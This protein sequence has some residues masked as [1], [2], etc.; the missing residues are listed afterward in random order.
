MKLAVLQSAGFLPIPEFTAEDVRGVMVAMGQP[1]LTIDE[2]ILETL[3]RTQVD[4]LILPYVRGNFSER[5]MAGLL[6]FQSAGGSLLFLGDLPNHDA[7]FPLRNME[8]WRLNLTRCN[9]GMCITGL[10]PF[11]QELLGNLPGLEAMSGKSFLLVR[12]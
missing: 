3:D 10:T 2:T 11:G 5:A 1:C 4:T 12:L 6:L 8:S 7:W 9:D